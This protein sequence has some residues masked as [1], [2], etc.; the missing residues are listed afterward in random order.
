MRA[1][2]FF[3]TC[4]AVRPGRDSGQGH[5]IGGTGDYQGA[6][7]PVCHQSLILLLDINCEDPVLRK[8]ARRKFGTLKRIPL[9]A[10]PRCVCELSYRLENDKRIKIV[11]SRYGSP[12]SQPYEDYPDHFPRKPFSLD[13]T[14]PAK[15][16]A[17]I[18]KWD[19]DVD[20][21]GEKLTKSERKLLE[22]FCGHPVF[23]PRYMYHHQLGGDSLWEPWDENQFFCPNKKCPGG[24]WD[25]MLK[26]GRPMKFLAGVINDPPGGLPLV[27][28]L[29]KKTATDWNY[30]VSYYFQICDKCLTVTTFS[31]SD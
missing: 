24:I 18:K 1:K 26:R 22:D 27:E 8:A 15:L 4:F 11:Q 19:P 10:C 31:T 3:K 6:L 21:R 12:G 7:C 9:F 23:I 16:P 25:K 5:W 20:L 14:I 2:G 30:F 29:S 17:V 28:P 13:D